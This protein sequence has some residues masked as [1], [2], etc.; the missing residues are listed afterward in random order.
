MIQI[1]T[2]HATELYFFKYVDNYILQLSSAQPT[3]THSQNYDN[4][5]ARHVTNQK[6]AFGH[7]PLEAVASPCS[8][9]ESGYVSLTARMSLGSGIKY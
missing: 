3:N 6:F 1:L 8:R 5:F 9:P 2:T 7:D 4:V